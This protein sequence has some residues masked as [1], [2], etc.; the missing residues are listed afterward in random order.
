MAKSACTPIK[1]TTVSYHFYFPL[2]DP[3]TL[4]RNAQAAA[5]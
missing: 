2:M 4:Q 5:S 1:T 3:G